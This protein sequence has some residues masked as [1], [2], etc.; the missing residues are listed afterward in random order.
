MM[1]T[2]LMSLAFGLPDLTTVYW[3]CLIVGGGLLLISTL[4]GGDADAGVDVDVD[5]DLDVDVDAD[6]SGDVSAEAGHTGH[7]HAGSLAAWFSLQFVVFFMAAF[8]LI[9]VTM[10]NLGS[11]TSGVTFAAALLGG[12]VVGQIVHQALRH[13]RKTS[14]DSTPRRDDYVDK[15]ARVTVAVEPKRKGEI[16]LRVGRAERFIPAVSSRADTAFASGDQVAV[17]AYRNG[18]AEVVSR[19]EYEFLNDGK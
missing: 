9:G 3:I 7:A 1:N 15:L 11:R 17:V 18:V 5:V 6:L 14:G 4:V 2:V 16:A 13:L 19:K 10:S 8:G 12:L